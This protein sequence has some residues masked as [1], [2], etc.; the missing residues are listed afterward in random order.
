MLR[1]ESAIEIVT[2]I[3]YSVCVAFLGVT[4]M[5]LVRV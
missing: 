2:A 5:G 4:D 3:S 1:P